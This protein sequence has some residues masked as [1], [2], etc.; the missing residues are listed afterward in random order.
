MTTNKTYNSLPLK[1]IITGVHG[2]GKLELAQKICTS[3][4]KEF[5]LGKLFTDRPSSEFSYTYNGQILDFMSTE[6]I[7]LSFE[8]NALLFISNFHD[9][10]YY[11][12]ITCQEF[13]KNNI[14]VL[15]PEHIINLPSTIFS[16]YRILFIWL[17][18]KYSSRRTRYIEESRKYDFMERESFDMADS[19]TMQTFLNNKEFLYFNN[20]IPE[21]IIPIV[22]TLYRSPEYINK[23]VNGYKY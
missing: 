5:K 3:N 1:I 10:T 22:Y 9:N 16:L 4:A 15:T 18:N 11:E 13:E 23:F 21:R 2:S 7:K 19:E 12:G 20:E 8:N 17:D 6:D 14:F